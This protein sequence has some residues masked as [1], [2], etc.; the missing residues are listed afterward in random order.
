MSTGNMNENRRARLVYDNYMRNIRGSPRIQVLLQTQNRLQRLL[1]FWYPPG[2][3]R[4]NIPELPRR[5]VQN[6]LQN[7]QR[8]IAAV[9]RLQDHLNERI[10]ENYEDFKQYRSPR[11]VKIMLLNYYRPSYP[12]YN[13]TRVLQLINSNI[14]RQ[15]KILKTKRNATTGRRETGRSK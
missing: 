9:H 13:W 4:R 7:L 10:M 1:N 5:L 11:N 14:R 12:N 3:N 15:N 6:S 8:R 2:S